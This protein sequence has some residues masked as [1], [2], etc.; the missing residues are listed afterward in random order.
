MTGY[1]Y[2]P[3]GRGG[4]LDAKRDREDRYRLVLTTSQGQDLAVREKVGRRAD[5]IKLGHRAAHLAV[6]A[7]ISIVY[8]SSTALTIA[9]DALVGRHVFRIV[10]ARGKATYRVSLC[11]GNETVLAVKT[12]YRSESA[13]RTAAEQLRT[14]LCP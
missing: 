5:K 4:H 11:E 10:R 7:A 13:A 9:A 6:D 3:R 8:E 14:M 2:P 1:R 12:I